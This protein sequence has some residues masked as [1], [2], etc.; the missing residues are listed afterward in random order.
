MD[1]LIAHGKCTK[2]LGV[3]IAGDDPL[4]TD[5]VAAEAMG[6]NPRG[7]EYLR[8]AERFSGGDAEKAAKAKEYL[9]KSFE[10]AAGGKETLTLEQYKAA[11]EERAKEFRSK[12]KE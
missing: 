1:G 8:L 5:F 4:A 7:T 6:F 10:K 3:I 11:R 12:K 2:K 9:S